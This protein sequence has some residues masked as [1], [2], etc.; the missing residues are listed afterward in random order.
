M[1]RDAAIAELFHLLNEAIMRG[2]SPFTGGERELIAVYVLALNGCEYCCS[3]YT[4]VAGAFGI[5][6]GLVGGLVYNFDAAA[7]D[8]GRRAALAYAGKLTTSHNGLSED[9]VVMVTAML[10]M[11]NNVIHGFG[12]PDQSPER[13]AMATKRLH[14]VGNYSAGPQCHS[15]LLLDQSR[16]VRLRRRAVGPRHPHSQNLHRIRAYRSRPH[17]AGSD[18]RYPRLNPARLEPRHCCVA[19]RS[20]LRA[21]RLKRRVEGADDRC[22][23]DV[24]CHHHPGHPGKGPVFPHPTLMDTP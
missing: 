13:L 14:K 8:D 18:Q 5:S 17:G 22:R 9:D 15:W 3:S 6:E 23:Y 1:K 7:V 10:H 20:R 19:P 12:T 4:P 16:A 21:G 24:V 2:P 11:A